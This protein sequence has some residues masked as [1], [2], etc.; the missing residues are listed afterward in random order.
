MADPKLNRD[1]DRL[2]S[3]LVEGDVSA[4]EKLALDQV[5]K[6][7]ANARRRYVHYLDLH[8]ELALRS[9]VSIQQ[10]SGVFAGLLERR[11]ATLL[12][13]AAA[14]LLIAFGALLGRKSLALIASGTATGLEMGE[15]A[16]AASELMDDGVAVLVHAVDAEWAM[17]DPPSS[18]SILSPGQLK[19][20]S[21][22]VLIEF[23]SGARLITEGSVSLEIVSSNQ[24]IFHSGKLRAF[25]PPHAEGFSVISPQFELVDLG[26]EFGL[27]VGKDGRSEVQVFDGKVELYPP[28][29][30][31]WL[32][33]RQPLHGGSGLSKSAAG[34]TSA[35]AAD[36]HSFPSFEEFRLRNESASQ[37]RYARWKM[38]NQSLV[39]DPRIAARFDFESD[40]PDKLIGSKQ[41]QGDGTIV[42]A[43]RADGRWVGKGALAFTRPGDRVRVNIPGEF[44]SLTIMAWIRVD[45]APDRQQSLLLTDGHE[46]GRLH[47]QIRRD[48][49]LRLSVR[50]SES[51]GENAISCSSPPF[52]NPRRI[53]AWSFVCSVYD[54]PGREVRHYLDG[55]EISR[56]TIK[57]HQTVKIGLGDIGN[58][59]GVPDQLNRSRPVR[60]FCGR[61]DEMTVWKVALDAEQISE[62]YRDSRL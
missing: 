32:K 43:K 62:L 9:E 5:L 1:L 22:M 10:K 56:H 39:N 23:Y 14:I 11:A 33:Q 27:E 54:G 51:Y 36:P 7:D 60:N 31:R 18:G 8:D 16:A 15:V 49:A 37:K 24:A 25:V 53:G 28:D 35:I 47:W 46:L 12:A 42:G 57:E 13:L 45:A 52:L 6:S 48:G 58:W 44:D 19:I 41:Q 29:G 30:K 20:D 4:D 34:E 38:L 40:S 50:T 17:S 26:T 61:I 2:L 3:K 55:D 59:M 21:G